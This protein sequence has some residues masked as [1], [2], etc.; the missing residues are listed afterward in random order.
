MTI[1]LAL[2]MQQMIKRNALIRKL[3]AVETL[4]CATVVCS[5][6]TGTLT[7]N[8]MTVVQGWAGGRR[9][10]L[11]GEGY[12]PIGQLFV[13]GAPAESR[14]DPDVTVLLHGAL[15]CND[16]KLEGDS[17]ASG[18]RSWRM[19]GDPTE[20]ALVV[21]AAKGGFHREDL[22][23]A[24][25]R[26]QEI[27]FDSDR[28]RMTTIHRGDSASKPGFA[29]DLRVSARRRVRQGRARHHPGPLQPDSAGRGD[30]G[31]DGG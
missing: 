10:R 31:A 23:S 12:S 8:E 9:L 4:G 6:K 13:D 17:D 27:P 28:K 25:P 19:V 26:V 21:A 20:G 1:C 7:Q 15:L 16:A 29:T 5:D 2:G 30:C 14:T 11:T 22:E 18:A 24:L 3:P